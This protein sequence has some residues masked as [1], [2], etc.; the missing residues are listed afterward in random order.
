MNYQGFAVT[1]IANSTVL[2]AGLVSTVE[3]EKTISAVLV[4]TSVQ[5]GALIEGWIGN[6]RVLEIPDY[7]LDTREAAGAANA[8]KGSTKIA[9]IPVEIAIPVG[10]IFKIGT[11]SAAVIC[12]IAGAYEYTE[13]A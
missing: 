7:C 13:K 2:D 1:G 3:S 11:R 4:N 9:R 10:Q 12:S 8:Y 6:E 5:N